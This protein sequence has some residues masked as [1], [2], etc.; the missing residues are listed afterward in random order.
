LIREIREIRA[1][2][3]KKSY[4]GSWRI[5]RNDLHKLFVPN[6]YFPELSVRYVEMLI[7]DGLSP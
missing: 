5:W 1:I 6:K 3:G 2:R 4:A 7:E